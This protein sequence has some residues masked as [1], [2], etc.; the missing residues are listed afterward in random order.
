[1]FITLCDGFLITMHLYNNYPH[2]HA[3]LLVYYVGELLH[4]ESYDHN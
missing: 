3:F 2:L 4:R 1:M